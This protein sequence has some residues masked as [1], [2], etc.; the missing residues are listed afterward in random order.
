MEGEE[1]TSAQRR[2]L[3][4]TTIKVKLIQALCQDS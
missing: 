4:D 2:E 1:I 3:F